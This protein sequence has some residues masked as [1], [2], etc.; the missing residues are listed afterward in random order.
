M[1]LAAW[2]APPPPAE[3][4]LTQVTKPV[5]FA[6]VKVVVDQHCVLCHNAQVQNKG[7]A[8]HTPELIKKNAQAMYQQAVVLKLMPFNNVTQIT[9]SE[10]A[11]IRRWYE[12]GIPA[13]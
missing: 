10:R 2:I 9:D 11:T 3:E 13:N 5:H 6:D 8:L 12:A 1:G 4:E 7:I